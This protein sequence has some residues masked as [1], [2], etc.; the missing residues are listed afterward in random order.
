M[1]TRTMTEQELREFIEDMARLRRENTAT[2]EKARQ[3]LI[4]SGYLTKDGQ[5]AYPYAPDKVT[6]K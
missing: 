3:F 5:V 4:K 1:P 6:Q 2:P